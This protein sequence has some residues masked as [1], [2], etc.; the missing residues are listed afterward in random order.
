MD[1]VLVTT[2]NTYISTFNSYFGQFLEWG[3][4]LFYSLL[5]I[6][7]AWISLW[8]AFDKSS[9][10]DSVSAFIKHF[11]AIAIFYSVMINHEWLLQLLQ[12]A[13][14][15]GKALTGIPLDPVA[16]I[17]NGIVIANKILLLAQQASLVSVGVGM[18]ITFATW[19]VV[20]FTF[21]GV[22]L[23]LALTLIITTACITVT[24]FFLAFAALGITSKIARQA[25]DAVLANCCKLLGIYLA[26][27]VGA[28]GIKNI[29][30][31]LPDK[32]VSF[33]IYVWVIACCLLFWL[34]AKYLPEQL[35][36]VMG[37]F[38]RNAH[39]GVSE[40][41]AGALGQ[42]TAAVGVAATTASMTNGV[43]ASTPINVVAPKIHPQNLSCDP[44]VREK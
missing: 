19:G 17:A 36:N 9:F 41:H 43:S 37:N 27:G 2:I 5:I 15:M 32:I 7:I 3:K 39:S 30:N 22:A 21:V 16:I 24:S 35:G 38:L 42:V 4:W 26:V 25:L 40:G 33:D 13:T 11:F 34:V 12:T 18:L 14:F 6:N 31:T 44:Q 20:I 1:A 8:Y 28:P 23:H 29:A 10:V